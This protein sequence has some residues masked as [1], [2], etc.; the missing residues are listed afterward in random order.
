MDWTTCLLSVCFLHK[1]L[2]QI[3]WDGPYAVTVDGVHLSRRRCTPPG[4]AGLKCPRT[5]V[6]KP[7][8]RRVQRFL[9]LARLEERPRQKIHL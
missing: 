2:A 7:G 4:I 3:P 8:M 1:T 5:S 9:Y 6:W